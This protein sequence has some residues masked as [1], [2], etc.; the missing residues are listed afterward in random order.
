MA[1]IDPRSNLWIERSEIGMEHFIGLVSIAIVLFASTNVDDVLVLVGFFAD[2][3]FHAR[4][5][6]AGQYI[7]IGALYCVSVGAALISLVIPTPYIGLLGLAPILIGLKKAWELRKGTDAN[8]DKP[9]RHRA[10][11]SGR[12]NI[13]AVAAVTIANGGD[14]I[15]IYTPLFATRSGYDIAI[16]GVVFAVMTLMWLIVA[17]WLTNHRMIGAPIRRYGGRVVPLVL[18][19]L[20]IFI[21]YE[22]GTFSL[23]RL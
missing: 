12:G 3:K 20:G 7:G 1:Q 14:N 21:L 18:V 16:I 10:A 17:H 5:V 13:A 2:P 4:Q 23:L 11:F 19:A 22:A 6:M 8:E 15:S 9:G